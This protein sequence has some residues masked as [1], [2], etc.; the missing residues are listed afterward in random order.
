MSTLHPP[1]SVRH[2][3]C[4]CVLFGAAPVAWSALTLTLDLSNMTAT[5]SGEAELDI[6]TLNDDDAKVYIATTRLNIPP[7]DGYI[8]TDPSSINETYSTEIS[9]GSVSVAPNTE[10]IYIDAATMLIGVRVVDILDM[11]GPGLRSSNVVATGDGVSYSIN[12]DNLDQG[13]IDYLSGAN[14]SSLRFFRSDSP[15]NDLG[16]AGTVVVIPEPSHLAMMGLAGASLLVR[17]RR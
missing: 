6:N 14:G 9:N 10:R 16:A 7:L 17:R 1:R 2:V 13:D 11:D 3:L 12:F 15:E 5:W 8:E 4:F